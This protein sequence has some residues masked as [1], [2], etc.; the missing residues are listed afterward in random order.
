MSR[1][2]LLKEIKSGF[3]G[4]SMEELDLNS[5]RY[6]SRLMEESLRTD[7]EVYE[8]LLTFLEIQY[9]R[10]RALAEDAKDQ[11]EERAF[12]ELRDRYFALL[13]VPTV[14][15]V[16]LA[17]YCDDQSKHCWEVAEKEESFRWH[18]LARCVGRIA[19]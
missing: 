18:E 19:D 6:F 15:R 17:I 13:R 12:T 4:F 2:E 14:L 11:F 8:N 9:L 10:F 3:D 5:H 16:N 7:D 1:K